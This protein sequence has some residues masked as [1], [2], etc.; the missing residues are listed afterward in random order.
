MWR[1][2]GLIRTY[3][4]NTNHL[5]LRRAAIFVDKILKGTKPADLPASNR[6]SLTLLFQPLSSL[7]VRLDH[8]TECAGA[9]G[10]SHQMTSESVVSFTERTRERNQ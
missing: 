10:S 2:G 6:L 1:D 7:A 9:G 4:V 5:F 3:G 8:S